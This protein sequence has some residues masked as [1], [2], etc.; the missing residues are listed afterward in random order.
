MSLHKPLGKN[1][2]HI[3]PTNQQTTSPISNRTKA[4]IAQ[5]Q[6]ISTQP[7]RKLEPRVKKGYW[8]KGVGKYQGRYANEMG[9]T[10]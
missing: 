2:V 4:R 10:G 6:I 3:Q 9:I 7:S 5:N 8:I 1:E